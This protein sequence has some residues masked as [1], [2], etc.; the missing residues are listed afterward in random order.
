MLKLTVDPERGYAV[1]EVF[2]TQKG[3]TLYAIIPK[4]SSNKKVIL[5]QLNVGNA[6]VTLFETGQALQL[7][8]K[9]NK[10]EI[11]LPEFDLNKIK[12]QYAFVIK[13][14]GVKQK[15]GRLK[16]LSGPNSLEIKWC[17]VYG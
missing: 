6:S 16:S 4:W 5:K 14:D 3:K 7:Q 15:D 2:F 11:T 13:I 8:V 9:G 17:S 12:S 10:I 1:R